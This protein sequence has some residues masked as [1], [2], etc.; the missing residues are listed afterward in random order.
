MEF[1]VAGQNF[2]STLSSGRGKAIRTRLNLASYPV[3]NYRRFFVL[4][5]AIGLPALILF[6]G[7]WMRM[8]QDRASTS[9]RRTEMERLRTDIA[10][11]RTQRADLEKFFADPSTRLVTQQAAFLNSIID[12]RSFPWTQFF[13]DLER[14]LPGGVRILTVT[15]SLSGDQVRV[16]MRVGALNDKSKLDFLKA[17]EEA[18]EFSGLELVSESRPA[19][20][21]DDNDVVQLDLE[22]DYHASSPARK[23]NQSGGAQ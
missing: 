7:L 22:A 14:R 13:L 21:A 2:Q 16:K 5:I 11:M 17:L 10:A 3:V 6:G 1:V 12:D 15:P 19:K 8:I 4:A 20:T 9:A 18:K 23:P